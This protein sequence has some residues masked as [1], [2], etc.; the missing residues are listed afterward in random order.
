M[1]Y[2]LVRGLNVAAIFEID[3]N[4]GVI[5]LMETVELD[6]TGPRACAI[7]PDGRFMLI[8]ALDSKE[9]LVWKIRGDGSLTPTGH[10][11]TQP[12]PG[13]VTFFNP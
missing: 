4:I 6:G 2:S 7:S 12:N 9:V 13:T 1:L 3:E 10:K 11:I 8:A 5:R